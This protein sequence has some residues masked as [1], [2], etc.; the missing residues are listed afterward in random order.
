M[1]K[2][3][4]SDKVNDILGEAPNWMIR[5]GI[6]IIFIIII[7]IIAGSALISY[8]DVVNT[9]IIVTTKIPPA[10]IE[11]RTEGRLQEVYVDAQDKVSKNEILGVIENTANL[12]DVLYVKKNLDNLI[13]TPNIS[14]DSIS[15]LF[16]SNL[17]L[18]KTQPSYYSFITKLKKYITYKSS[19]AN[20]LKNLT[21]SYKIK[22]R[23]QIIDQQSIQ[24]LQ[25]NL[26]QSLQNLKNNILNW[27]QLYVLKSP[28]N[29]KVALFDLWNRYQNINIG[30]TVFII[31]PQQSTEIIGRI[32]IPIKNSAKVKKGQQ[33][34]IKLDN[35]PYQEWGS[36]SGKITSISEIPRKND[37]TYTAYIEIDSLITSF[38]NE[39]VFKQEMR[40]SAEI[41]TEE[42]T[43]L[44][45]IFYQLNQVF[46]KNS[47]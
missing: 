7:L 44:E 21:T 37:A 41:I 30:E 36:V 34:I 47:S 40:G 29:G 9:N 8:N 20:N 16:P 43:I 24:D 25:E 38:D 13:I 45:R 2:I 23:D 33:V 42:L 17:N 28:I 3:D 14:L 18:G 15:N 4:R 11:A 32:D 46:S 5:W 6:T 39:V 35:Y 26:Y 1:N 19:E 27:E 10:Y 31:V 22:K 12:Q